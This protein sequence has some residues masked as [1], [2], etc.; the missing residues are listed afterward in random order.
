MSIH[1]REGKDYLDY[2]QGFVVHSLRAL[3]DQPF[4]AAVV[5]RRVEEEFGLKIPV[6]TFA[7]YLKRLVKAGV[8]SPIGAG[9]QFRVVSLPGTDIESER[10]STRK[11]ID[12]VVNELAAFAHAR[13]SLAWDDTTAAAALTEFLRQYSIDFLKFAEVRSPLPQVAA[14]KTTTDYVVAAFVR[15][16]AKNQSGL[17]ES[18]KILVQ[19]HML[20]NALLCPD[21]EFTTRGFKHTIFFVDTRFVLKAIDLESQFDTENTRELLTTIRKLGGTVCIFPETK[22][23]IHSVLKAII[24][25]MQQGTGRRGVIYWELMKRRR[26]VTDVILAESELEETLK[27]LSISTYPSPKYEEKYYLFQIGEDE[28][29]DEIEG[30]IDYQTPQAAEHDIR[31]VRHIFALRKGRRAS[32]IEDAKFVF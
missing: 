25:G 2:L 18:I 17:F 14:D 7:I 10:D 26:G 4:D 20:A 32:S 29:R 27:N 12:E 16:C 6:A 8:V 30:E 22:E 3:G 24:K 13:Y 9:V 28:L 19:S 1:L 21:L 11:H 5:Q 23:E 31:V 15:H